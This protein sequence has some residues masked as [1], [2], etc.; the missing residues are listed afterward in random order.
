MYFTASQVTAL[1]LTWSGTY[2][3]RMDGNPTA[4]WDSGTIPSASASPSANFHWQTSTNQNQTSIYVT[5]YIL[6]EAQILTTK[7]NSAY[8]VLYQNTTTSGTKLSSTG[9]SYFSNVVPDLSLIAPNALLTA[10]LALELL[11][12][13]VVAT[14]YENTIATD[15]Q[16]VFYESATSGTIDTVTF[17]NGSNAVV[18]VNTAFTSTMI[19]GQIKGKA[20]GIW[21][22][23]SAVGDGQH[24]TLLT[25]YNASGGAGLGYDLVYST[26]TNTNIAPANPLSLD[27]TADALVVPKAVFGTVICLAI[28]IFVMIKGAQRANSYKPLILI[29]LPLLYVFTRIGWIPMGLTIA[30]GILSLFLICWIFFFEKTVY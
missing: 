3:M 26:S 28:M 20:D 1:G 27:T 10:Q 24:L 12:T 7:W 21:Y 17:V 5:N 9:Q 6:S 19:N 2:T 30:L 25:P 11:R 18:G 14:P 13:P 8:Y 16:G 29:T 4:S 22:V 23:I 15:F